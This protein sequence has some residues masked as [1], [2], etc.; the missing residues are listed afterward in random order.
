MQIIRNKTFHII[1]SFFMFIGTLNPI[2]II[3]FPITYV[4]FQYKNLTH[5]INSKIVKLKI[6]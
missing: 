4:F 5:D 3:L 6:F 2:I 1:D